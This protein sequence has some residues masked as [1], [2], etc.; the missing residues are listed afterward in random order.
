MINAKRNKKLIFNYV[1]RT[2]YTTTIIELFVHGL[3]DISQYVLVVEVVNTVPNGI[4]KST[5]DP[6]KRMMGMMANEQ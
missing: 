1:Q 2:Q 5:K 4:N 6:R 3:S